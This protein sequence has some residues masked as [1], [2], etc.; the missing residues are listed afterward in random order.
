MQEGDTQPAEIA[1][2]Y[3]YMPGLIMTSVGWTDGRTA[4]QRDAMQTFT[5]CGET[6]ESKN[7]I[8]IGM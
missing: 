6:N 8:N 1:Y 7:T 5:P 3:E 2:R 4:V